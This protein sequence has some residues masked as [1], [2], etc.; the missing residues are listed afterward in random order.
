V[1]KYAARAKTLCRSLLAGNC[2]STES[3]PS[4]ASAPCG[5]LC[6]ARSSRPAENRLPP[7]RSGERT[8]AERQEDSSRSHRRISPTVPT[9]CQPPRDGPAPQ[10]GRTVDGDRLRHGGR[11]HTGPNCAQFANFRFYSGC[12]A[13]LHHPVR[14]A[15]AIMIWAGSLV[16]FDLWTRRV[17]HNRAVHFCSSNKRCHVVKKLERLE[18]LWLRILHRLS[19]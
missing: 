8:R 5:S 11:R 18:M 6:V 3:A 1:G 10:A 12:D 2:S 13:G 16:S 14:A 7:C 15:A 4:S 17:Q 9:D 19:V